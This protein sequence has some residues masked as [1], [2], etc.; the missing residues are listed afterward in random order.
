L[1][2]LDERFRSQGLV[3][4]AITGEKA[5]VVKRFLSQQKIGYPVLLDP[6][7]KV[8]ELFRVDGFPDSFICN[9]DGHFVARPVARPTM[10]GFLEM[11]ALAGLR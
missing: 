8:R 3:I 6:G 5:S 1:V 4:L 9:R 7:Q 11:L 10:Q 2:A